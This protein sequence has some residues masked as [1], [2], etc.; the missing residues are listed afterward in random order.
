MGFLPIFNFVNLGCIYQVPAENLILFK[1]L[2]VIQNI[3][4]GICPQGNYV[5]DLEAKFTSH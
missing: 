3:T 4:C 2:R 1:M 5:L